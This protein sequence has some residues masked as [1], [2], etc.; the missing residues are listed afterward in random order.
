M[1]STMTSTMEP[2]GGKEEGLFTAK[3]RELESANHNFY[4]E[5]HQTHTRLDLSLDEGRKLQAKNYVLKRELETA[6]SRICH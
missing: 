2:E 4:S 6:T 5:L 1:A 3:I